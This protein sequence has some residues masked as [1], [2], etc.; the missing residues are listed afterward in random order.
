[1]TEQ[2][3]Q[4]HKQGFQDMPRVDAIWGHPAY[5]TAYRALARCEADRPYCRHQLRHLLDVARIMWIENL[6]TS[7]GLDREVVY[8][9]ALLHDIG[10][11]VQYATGAPHELVG[12]RLADEILGSLPTGIVFLPDERA[13]MVEAIRLHRKPVPDAAPLARL[14]Y[15]ADKASRPCYAC[16]TEL[17][18][19]CT[20]PAAKQNLVVRV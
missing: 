10:K 18:E 5:Q 13:A 16:T 9:T 1:M 17:R 3:Y 15:R 19:A 6:E 14:L 7:C 2:I 4:L 11:A 20:W 8:G 12:A